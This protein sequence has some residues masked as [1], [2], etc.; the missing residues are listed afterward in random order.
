MAILNGTMASPEGFAGGVVEDHHQH[1]DST[2]DF[3]ITDAGSHWITVTSGFARNY[4]L[5]FRHNSIQR[6]L[7][8]RP[9]GQRQ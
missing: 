8:T 4:N 2:Q 9:G 6:R 1:R 3:D 5:A 7:D